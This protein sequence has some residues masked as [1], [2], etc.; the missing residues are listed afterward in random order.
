LTGILSPAKEES[1]G[2]LR[3]QIQILRCCSGWQRAR[4][5]P[6]LGRRAAPFRFRNH[7]Y[8]REQIGLPRPADNRLFLGVSTWSDPRSG[9][10]PGQDGI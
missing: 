10:I 5:F 2:G 7:L 4:V 1:V 6:Q 3:I 9:W 8:R